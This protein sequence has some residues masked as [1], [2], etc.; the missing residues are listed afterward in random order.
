MPEKENAVVVSKDKLL[1]DEIKINISSIANLIGSIKSHDRAYNFIKEKRPSLIFIDIRDDVETGLALAER[2]KR[3]LPNRMLFAIAGALNS[4]LILR[5]LRSGFTDYI[6]FPF[7]NNEPLIDIVK[8]AQQKGKQS[9]R[10]GEILIFSSNKGGQGVTTIALNTADHIQRL[11]NGRVLLVDFNMNSG[12]IAVFLDLQESYTPLNLIKDIERL[13]ENLLFS[14]IIKH[15]S[16]FYILSAPENI[17][18]S[19]SIT[20]EDINKMFQ[21]L[22][23][24]MDYIIVDL[25]DGFSEKTAAAFDIADNIFLILQQSV[26]SVKSAKKLIDLFYNVGYKED[27]VKI[28]INRYEEKNLIGLHDIEKLISQKIYGSIANDYF[29]ASDAVNRGELIARHHSGSRIDQD[30]SALAS[31]ITNIKIED[32]DHGRK[33]L[34]KKWL[35][36]IYRGNKARERKA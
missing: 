23:S 36:S 6:L 5:S 19:A 11:F 7:D 14:S 16:G 4:K 28:I 32:N 21:V 9:R 20:V 22:K 30:I 8:A 13:D 17:T 10:A 12:D 29:P 2:V 34:L 18:D 1:I 27:K 35:S 31:R 33:K 26:P 15:P 24:F 25:G 3:L